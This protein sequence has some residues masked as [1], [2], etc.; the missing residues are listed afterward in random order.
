MKTLVLTLVLAIPGLHGQTLTRGPYLQMAT[1]TSMTI[2]WKTSTNM[3]GRVSLGTTM[4][5]LNI[6]VDEATPGTEHL[7]NVTGLTPSTTYY[8][9]LGTNGQMLAGGTPDYRFTTAPATGTSA[10]TRILAFGDSGTGGPTQL[11]VRDA[12]LAYQGNRP[13]DVWLLL[14]DNAYG[15]G[16]EFEYQAYF[17]DKYPQILRRTPAWSCLGNHDTANQTDPSGTYP[18]FQLFSFPTAGECGG[19]ASGLEHYYSFNHGQTHFICLDSMTSD[20]ST[21]GAMANWLRSDLASA[22]DSR[23]IIAFWHHPPYS[24][25]THNS[26]TELPMIQMRTN[27]VPIL[28]EGGVDLILCG[29]SHAYERSCLLDGHYGISNTLTPAM[30]KNSGDGRVNGDGPYLKPR[31]RGGGHH[32]FVQAIAGSAGSADGGTFGHPA[33]I[34]GMNIPGALV[35]DVDDERLDAAMVQP[36]GIPSGSSFTIADSFTILKHANQDSD[37]DGMPDDYETTKGLNP[38]NHADAALDR[39]DDGIT[40]FEEYQVSPQ[41][42]NGVS[43]RVLIQRNAENTVSRLVFFTAAGFKHRI[44]S[45]EDLAGWSPASDWIAGDDTPHAWT[46]TALP[47]PLEGR[48]MFRI[49]ITS[50]PP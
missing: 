16:Q 8:Y 50:D 40:N 31:L 7:V 21:T 48:R 39:N 28:E 43:H 17:F 42:A 1:E 12:I 41:S 32:G 18:Y 9:G 24:K 44:L 45:S 36:T 3:T 2:R 14:G 38:T 27:F 30:K 22:T 13:A 34:H 35:I 20:R 29:H 6:H 15:S 19:V 4:G 26:D 11:A 33:I 10:P 47:A 37:G 25:G 49:E 46:D 23:W 5:N